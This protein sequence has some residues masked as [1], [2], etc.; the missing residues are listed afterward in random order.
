MSLKPLTQEEL[1]K[2][3]KAYETVIDKEIK[4]GK[5]TNTYGR[6]LLNSAKKNYSSQNYN[7]ELEKCGRK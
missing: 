2:S 7:R 4:Q 5:L 1:F 3:Y 6:A